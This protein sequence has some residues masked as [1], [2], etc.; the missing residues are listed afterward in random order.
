MGADL[1]RLFDLT[2]VE[3]ERAELAS[4]VQSSDD[5]II[6]KTLDGTITSWNRSAEHM[7]G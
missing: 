2:P 3:R 7:Y 1:E 5:A 4:I 6:G